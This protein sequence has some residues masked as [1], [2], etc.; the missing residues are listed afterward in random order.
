VAVKTAAPQLAM[1]PERRARAEESVWAT[2]TRSVW[3]DKI[4]LAAYL[5]ILLVIGCALTAQWIAP[6]DPG[7]QDLM[8]RLRPPF[9]QERGLISYPLGT[10]ALGRDILSRIIYGTR[11]SLIVG[12]SAVVVQGVIGVSMGLAAGFYGGRID[13]VIMRL[14]DV[15]YA[16]PFLVLA[17]AVMAVLGPS[18][19]NVILVLG[20]TG[21]VYYA[22]I[23]RAEVL[24]M[25]ERE[26]IEAARAIGVSNARMMLK[27]ILPNAATSIIVIASL[28]V[29]RMII[30]EA[31]LSFLGLGVPPSIPSWG[32][33]VAEGR[34]YVATAWWVS[35][36]PGV[37]ILATVMAVNVIGDHLRDELDPSSRGER[38]TAAT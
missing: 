3:R 10:D 27:H 23:V 38:E 25:R 7:A 11:I 6:H 14:A 33:M 32:S 4:T 17:I 28:Q 1:V 21:W 22:R 19:R 2:Y 20:I 26:F 5:F 35:A 29:A 9:W 34:N 31:S 18:L 37:A 15:Q 16:L 36:M 12:F 24:A 13:S 8:V 30:S